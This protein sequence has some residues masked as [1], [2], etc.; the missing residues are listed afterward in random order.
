MPWLLAAGLAPSE[1]RARDE[2]W[3]GVLQEV[4]LPGCGGDAGR[5]LE[6]AARYA[7]DECWGSLACR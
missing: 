6:A 7:N 4:A 5:F 2:N 1:A 3:C